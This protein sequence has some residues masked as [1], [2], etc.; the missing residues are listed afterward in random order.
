MV[1]QLFLMHY[2]QGNAEALTEQGLL[3]VKLLADGPLAEEIP[4]HVIILCAPSAQA[5]LVADIIA[6]KF[7]M[8]GWGIPVETTGSLD[9]YGDNPRNEM[10][11]QA[12]EK[13]EV[14]MWRHSVVL[15]I[16]GSLRVEGISRILG[17]GVSLKNAECLVY[18]RQQVLTEKGGPLTFS[19]ILTVNDRTPGVSVAPPKRAYLKRTFHFFQDHTTC[20]GVRIAA[21][22]AAVALA[23]IGIIAEVDGRFGLSGLTEMKVVAGQEQFSVPIHLPWITAP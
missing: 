20:R 19:G 9:D 16:T 11:K 1:K 23:A 14:A 22:A 5:K 2:A 17:Q 7:S 13:I 10:D 21:L 12:I 15:V 4:P 18:E 8:S 3:Q 6:A